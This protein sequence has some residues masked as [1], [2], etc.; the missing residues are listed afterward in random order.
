MNLPATKRLNFRENSSFWR[1]PIKVIRNT[2]ITMRHQNNTGYWQ[3]SKLQTP[4]PP[5]KPSQPILITP[6][7][8]RIKNAYTHCSRISNSAERGKVVF[9]VFVVVL[10]KCHFFSCHPF[11]TLCHPLKRCKRRVHRC[12]VSLSPFLQNIISIRVIPLHLRWHALFPQSLQHLLWHQPE[13]CILGYVLLQ[14]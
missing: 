12:F 11:V 14:K 10:S 9:V 4:T 5:T 8:H 2:C 1:H 3:N 6:W 7:V 13:R